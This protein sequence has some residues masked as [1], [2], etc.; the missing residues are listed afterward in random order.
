MK[1]HP[2][3][4]AFAVIGFSAF[5]SVSAAPA[6]AGGADKSPPEGLTATEWSSIREVH[7][8]WKHRFE[9]NRDGTIS[10]TNPGQSWDT[11]FD[12][13][14]FSVRP[15][16]GGWQWGLDL[17]TGTGSAAVGIARENR[18]S[19]NRGNGITEW[20]V[21]DGRGLEQGWT[22]EKPTGPLRLKV[23]GGLEAAVSARTVSFGG[24][25][26]YG[27]L[28]AWDAKG[29]TVRTWFEA[30]GEGFA[31]HYDDSDAAYPITIDPVAQQ[32]YLKSA[33][34]GAG[35]QFGITVSV[36]GDTVVVGAPFEDSNTTGVDSVPNDDGTANN[37]GAVYVFVR[38]GGIWSQQAYLK[39]SNTEANDS[40]GI[41]VSVSGDTLVAGATGEA[42]KSTGVDSVPDDDGSARFSGAA[43][44]F[45]RSGGI[46][47]QQA[48]LKASNT[49]AFD[50]FGYSV[51]VSG[52][53]VV[54]GAA[55][56]DSKSTGVDSVPDD[57]GTAN[58]SGAAYVFTRSGGTW[59]QQSYLK[60]SNTGVNDGFGLSV[61][62]S[63]DTVIVGAPGEDSNTTGVDS[64]P[65]DDGSAD[66]SG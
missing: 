3:L 56:E 10:A 5:S 6:P 65:D 47:S 50:Q 61:S 18:L 30:D 64:V 63:G 7:E 37:S 11:V 2:S 55:G 19:Y 13:R 34:T 4:A 1:V 54:V 29:R 26:T 62:V 45:F 17:V 59:S 33:N 14:G 21:N 23:R 16:T 46:W 22:L 27:G 57:D 60:A 38:S 9:E 39:A 58:F 15:R 8:A 24:Q 12:G 44:V 28:K 35:D 66:G 32:A 41:S 42:S 51:S 20:F 25:L 49:G 36:S 48:Y 53:T 43:Y 40:F 52:D 31:V